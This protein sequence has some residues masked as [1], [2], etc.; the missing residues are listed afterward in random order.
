MADIENWS[1]ATD[2]LL[3][4]AQLVDAV[5]EGVTRRGFTDVRPAH[6]FAFA[7]IS[8]GDATIADVAEYLGVTKQAA[9]Q[10]VHQLEERGYVTR[11]AHP[12]DARAAL[13]ALTR[14][15]DACT[16]AAQDAAGE[17]VER[18]RTTLGEPQ[19]RH[20]QRALRAIVQPGPL[21]PSW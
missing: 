12:L 3:L 20:L 15:G 11:Q 2:V 4:S 18:W 1:V 9:A 6:G 7:R 17:A 8:M 13:L 10:L 16:R 19:F 14:S 5:Q 21:R